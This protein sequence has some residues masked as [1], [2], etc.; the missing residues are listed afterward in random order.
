MSFTKT[1]QGLSMRREL[2]KFTKR[3]PIL[4]NPHSPN[5]QMTMVD[6][7]KKIIVTFL[8]IHEYT[9]TTV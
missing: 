1:T 2:L 3:I 5:I 9:S 8:L 7:N 4:K 6:V